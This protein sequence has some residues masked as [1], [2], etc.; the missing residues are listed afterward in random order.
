MYA[1]FVQ[2]YLEKFYHL[3][4]KN[5][6]SSIQNSTDMFVEKLKEMQHFFGLNVT[7]KPNA[8]TLE[9]MK[10]PRC[11]VP[12]SGEYMMTPGNPKWKHTSLTYR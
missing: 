3:Q 5:Y 12:D 4:V 2:N 9:M 10:R 8:E 11:G 1:Y 6:R 7:G